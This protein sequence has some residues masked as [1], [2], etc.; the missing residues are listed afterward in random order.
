MVV[1]SCASSSNV[2]RFSNKVTSSLGVKLTSHFDCGISVFTT[3]STYAKPSSAV[4]LRCRELAARAFTS[5]HSYT[6]SKCNSKSPAS[7]YSCCCAL[8][9]FLAINLNW[10]VNPEG[11]PYIFLTL[12]LYFSVCI[13]HNLLNH[14]QADSCTF[15]VAM[16]ALEHSK[17]TDPLPW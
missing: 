12:H 14:I 8:P 1:S 11:S 5:P 7:M 16:E 3:P 2:I 17:K 6:Y 15:H 4:K 9:L 10:Q 13:L